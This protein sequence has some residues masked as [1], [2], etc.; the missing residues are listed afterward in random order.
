MK[1]LVKR[2]NMLT[3][4]GKIGREWKFKLSDA[5]VLKVERKLSELRQKV[6]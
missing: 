6:D 5:D 4:D 2:D 1:R 3:M